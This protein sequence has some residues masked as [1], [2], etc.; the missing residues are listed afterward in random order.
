[1]IEAQSSALAGEP[2]QKKQE[3]SKGGD[4]EAPKIVE[5][6]KIYFLYRPRTGFKEAHNV[7]DVQRF[8]LV[9]AGCLMVQHNRSPI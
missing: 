1:M 3:T 4:T 5:D 2:A 8:F 7:S 6:G 9:S